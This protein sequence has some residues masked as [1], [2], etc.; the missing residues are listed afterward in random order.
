MVDKNAS[1]TQFHLKR[2]KESIEISSHNRN[3]ILSYFNEKLASGSVKESS[4]HYDL[5]VLFRLAKTVS[6]NFEKL[7][8]S[9]L[10]DFFVNLKPGQIILRRRGKPYSYSIEKYS[11]VT[12]WLYKQR[13]KAFWKWLFEGKPV[14]R[15]RFG[16]PLFV[17][18]IKGA[19]NFK[20]KFDK[21]ILSREEV[22]SMIKET[23]NVR[24][25]A[26]MAVLFEAGLRAGELL[27]MRKSKMWL[28]NDFCEFEVDG[29]TGK[30]N[31][32]LVKSYPYLGKWLD[33]LSSN[34]LFKSEEFKDFI[35]LSFPQ[36]GVSYADFKG[37][38]PLNNACLDNIV[39]RAAVRAGIE[40]RVWVHG[41]R[42][43]S[44]TDFA[45]QGYNEVEMK[46]KYGWAPNSTIPSNY[47]HYKYD[48]LK[49][50]ILSNH[51]RVVSVKPVDEN[52]LPTR[53]CPFC[54]TENP[55]ENE[56]C[57]KCGKPI[58]IKLIK[59]NEKQVQA[60]NAMQ[61]LVAQLR[62]L[63]NKGFDLQQFNVFMQEWTKVNGK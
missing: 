45:K 53:D 8:K 35:W 55:F 17:S 28:N 2:I 26:V 48:E 15:D 50:K 63:E 58:D 49:N 16:A 12:L 62:Q 37:T 33:V 11:E 61:G 3:L 21:H 52:I 46:L 6:K 31:V 56:F 54:S 36:A 44:A 24:D 42:H 5:L 30:R 43:A 20:Y 7:S 13:V 57:G 32:V 27:S 19:R 10:V 25:K 41:F 34:K 14:V 39:K 1:L 22:F 60:L 51:G 29:K 38:N 4:L 40:K 9:D 23:S 59:S 47:T 18:W